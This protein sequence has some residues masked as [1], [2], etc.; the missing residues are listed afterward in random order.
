MH[1]GELVSE[2][3]S[4]GHDMV[5]DAVAVDDVD[6]LECGHLRDAVVGERVDVLAQRAEP[7]QTVV[8]QDRGDGESRS[9][10][11]SD[12]DDIGFDVVLDRSEVGP[13]PAIGLQLVEDQETAE[14]VADPSESLQIASG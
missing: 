1:F 11:L 2:M 10:R 5:E 3:A 8:H 14:L 7:F 4:D 12:A 6:L 13:D 9:Q